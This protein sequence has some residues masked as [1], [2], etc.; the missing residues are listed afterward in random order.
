[1]LSGA[2]SAQGGQLRG[3]LCSL[4]N[5]DPCEWPVREPVSGMSCIKSVTE[6]MS[7]INHNQFDC[8]SCMSSAAVGLI[9]RF[10]M[11]FLLT[12]SFC[13]IVCSHHLWRSLPKWPC[14]LLFRTAVSTTQVMKCALLLP[15]VSQC[16]LPGFGVINVVQPLAW[17]VVA[18]SEQRQRRC[19]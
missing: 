10:S 4:R 3:F 14:S 1:M 2:G 15:P 7:F 16:T 6:H 19:S 13:G 11:L 5:Q 17:Q 18:A 12:F 9:Y 8:M